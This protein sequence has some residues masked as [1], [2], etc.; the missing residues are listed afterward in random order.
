MSLGAAPADVKTLDA[1][2]V[3]EINSGGE[4]LYIHGTGT[5]RD[6]SDKEYPIYYCFYYSSVYKNWGSCPPEFYGASRK[7]GKK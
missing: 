4:L 7:K 5:Y 3:A 6:M 1:K 2:A